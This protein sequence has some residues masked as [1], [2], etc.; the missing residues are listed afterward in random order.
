MI[1]SGS[2]Y[3][4]YLVFFHLLESSFHY[5]FPYYFLASQSLFCLLEL[6]KLSSMSLKFYFPSYL[7]PIS[8]LWRIPKPYLFNSPI[9]SQ[10]YTFNYLVQLFCL[11]Q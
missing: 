11:F 2:F 8:H 5:F 10:M 4:K 1:L 7:F 6:L 9:H 3:R